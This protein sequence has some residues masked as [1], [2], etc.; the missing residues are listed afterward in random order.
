MITSSYATY[1]LSETFMYA[2]LAAKDLVIEEKDKQINK[3]I[4]ENQYNQLVNDNLKEIIKGG[5]KS[6][7]L[8]NSIYETVYDQ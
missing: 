8:K 1:K 6:G 2:S 7:C 5:I 3:L 4:K